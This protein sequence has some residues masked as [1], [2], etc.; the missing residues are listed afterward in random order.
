MGCTKTR[1]CVIRWHWV[2]RER[3]GCDSKREQGEGLRRVGEFGEEQR[4]RI[5]VDILGELVEDIFETFGYVDFLFFQRVKDTHQGAT[6]MGT[7]IRGRA[8]ADLAGDDGGPE[9]AFR[10]VVFSRDLSVLCPM[11]EAMSVIPE[12]ILN[13]SDSEVEGGGLYRGDDLGFGFGSLLIKLCLVDG[14]VSETHCRGQ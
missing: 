11:I 14:L 3:A 2:F 13:A 12:E 9:V 4:E 1:R 6:R 7:R 10:E 5:L 8:E